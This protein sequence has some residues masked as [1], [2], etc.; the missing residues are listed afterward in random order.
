MGTTSRGWDYAAFIG[1]AA[2]K[3]AWANPGGWTP[4]MYERLFAL[5][6][7]N[8]ASVDAAGPTITVR[9]LAPGTYFVSVMAVDPYGQQVGRQ[10]YPASNELRVTVAG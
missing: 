1:T 9:G 3:T 7:S 10:L 5:P 4:D 2:A 8:V 6:P